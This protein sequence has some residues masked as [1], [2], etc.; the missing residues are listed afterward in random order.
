MSIY[1]TFAGHGVFTGLYYSEGA[2]AQSYTANWNNTTTYN[3]T[4]MGGLGN[5][6]AHGYAPTTSFTL[7]LTNMPAHNQV[8]YKVFWHMV[9]SLDSETCNLWTTNSAGTEIEQVRFFKLYSTNGV[10][11]QV[12]NT[13]VTTAW[14]G[15]QS[16]SYAPWSGSSV[17]GYATID[18][19]YYEHTA[20]SFSARHY[21][22]ADQAQDDEAMY[23]SHVEVYL[24]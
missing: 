5:V 13:G 1:N 18:T 2:T 14:S 11:Y 7:T 12:T 4:Q 16:Y 9:D 21:F 22:G 6:T 20:S 8:R 10:N 23:L 3:M 19:G 24:R 15:S 17:D